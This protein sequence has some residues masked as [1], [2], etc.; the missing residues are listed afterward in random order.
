MK[1]ALTRKK[2][3]LSQFT[4]LL[5]KSRKNLFSLDDYLSGELLMVGDVV[6]IDRAFRKPAQGEIVELDYQF[7]S[8]QLLAAQ[9]A[10]GNKIYRIGPNRLTHVRRREYYREHWQRVC[11][12]LDYYHDRLRGDPIKQLDK[13]DYEDRDFDRGLNLLRLGNHWELARRF[14]ERTIVKANHRIEAGLMSKQVRV[15]QVYD[16]DDAVRSKVYAAAMLDRSIE[17]DLLV[18]AA[19]ELEAYCAEV[20]PSHW[21]ASFQE[22]FLS[23]IRMTMIAGDLDLARKLIRSKRSFRLHKDQRDLLRK[24]LRKSVRPSREP[25]LLERCHAFLDFVRRPYASK[26]VPWLGRWIDLEWAVIVEKFI[27]EIEHP[28]WRSVVANLYR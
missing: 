1:P 15:G 11:G 26:C 2:D 18:K 14:F 9:V 23:T 6:S 21:N 8:F 27:N 20:G 16:I 12:D 7:K 28:D 10:V 17:S 3:L 4:S 25:E 5:S 19:R 22:M 13:H 24:L